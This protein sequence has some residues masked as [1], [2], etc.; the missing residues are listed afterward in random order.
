M[1]KQQALLNGLIDSAMDAIVS[2]D[3][4][5]NI[6]IFN[7]AA[8]LMFGYS[9]ADIIDQPLDKL[10]P[11][12]FRE[13][14]RQLV[15]EFG[16]TNITS[17][18]MNMPELSFGLRANGEEFPFEASISQVK[19]ENKTIY[20]AILRDISI[21]K[22]TEATLKQ[23]EERLRQA[24]N[25][26]G[27]GLFDLDHLTGKLYWSP[28]IRVIFGFGPD[29]PVSMD[30]VIETIYPADREQV[31]KAIKNIQD[32]AGAGFVAHSH[33]IVRR[34]GEVRWIEVRFQ[35]IFLGTGES[36][37]P[38]RSI[39]AVRDITHRKQS[40][41][42]L[43]LAASVYQASHEGIVVTDENN[44]IVAINPAFTN[45]TGYT[46][47]EVHGKNPRMF[48][49]GKQDQTFYQEMWQSIQNNGHWQ[50]EI[51]DRR[52][53]GELHAKWLSISAIRHPDGSIYRYVGQF[54]DI[55]D[56][57]RKDELI[58]TQ[59][60]FDALTNLPNR[61]LLADRMQQAISSSKRS[62]LF[63]ALV[64]L[65]LDH[66]KQL[67]DTLGHSTGDKLL[68]EVAHRLQT[69]IRQGDTIARMGGD[70]FLVVLQELSANQN[71]AAIKAEKIAE[72]IRSELC[73]PYQFGETEYHSSSSIGI[74]IFHSQFQNQEE[75]LA[76]VDAA[77]YQAKAK[78]RNSICFFDAAMQA[79]LE[80]R[81]QLENALRG[82]SSRHE[83]TLY[84]QLQVDNTGRPIGAEALL[85]W[86]N[87]QF[88][89]VLP[90]QF[91]PVAE[92]SGLILQIGHWV[93][94]TA[95]TQL[96]RWH[97]DP[98][99]CHLVIAVNVSARQFREP[100]FV[101][102][103]QDVLLK[104]GCKPEVLKLELT[105]SLVL[106]NVEDCISKMKALKKLGIKFSMDD[107]GTGY[108]SLSYIS[109]LPIDQIK[110]DQSFVRNITTDP[111]DAVIV[112]T[113]IS[114]THS[115]GM[116]VIAEGVETTAQRD[117]LELHGCQAYQ[118]YLYAKP[119][120]IEQL[121]HKL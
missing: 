114:M 16:K 84:Y 5:Q 101:T 42:A 118:G 102:Q 96:A 31:I 9:A 109:R 6:I 13:R 83:L 91:I 32:P 65:D 93:L 70:E 111:H 55:T 100:T 22:Q 19:V 44:L 94:E 7:P 86:V 40:E 82:A 11:I 47:D 104:T 95:C 48:Q 2:T 58:W 29:E 57:K 41:E 35:N 33:R 68:I 71:E 85:R 37:H 105:E 92:E 59:A 106:D 103:V 88:G 119:L 60:N 98:R 80:K 113:I 54:S 52:K 17:R 75:L 45:I 21:R 76:H 56:K 110:V 27:I 120:P 10:I 23:N 108:S 50:G 3:E 87:P 24:V 28:E 18:A 121:E 8:E 26:A 43:Q 66:F 4:S 81:S 74:V 112:Q 15:D 116:E 64:S 73:R 115:L 78:G 117:F 90:T 62:G 38:I 89:M 99:L 107:F 72:K 39:G 34:D 53:N 12:R 77:M 25:I 46:L 63:G 61:R 79:A 67:N 36:R 49:S 69:C 51:W 20:T 1:K 30:S 14:H 97:D